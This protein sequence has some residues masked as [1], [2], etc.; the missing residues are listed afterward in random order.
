[1]GQTRI[2]Y[3]LFSSTYN[4]AGFKSLSCRHLLN[5]YVEPKPESDS[6]AVLSMPGS[7]LWTNTGGSQVRAMLAHNDVLYVV[8]DDTFYSVDTAGNKTYRG[9]LT[10]RSGNIVISALNNYIVIADGTDCYSYNVSGATFTNI[11]DGDLPNNVQ[12][13]T[14]ANEYILYIKPDTALVYVSDLS[15]PESINALSFFT[16]GA[17]FD[18]LKSAVSCQNKAYL[19]GDTTTEIWYPSGGQTVPF[20]RETVIQ[21][22]IQAP[23]SCKTIGNSVYW[24]G[25]NKD[26]CV[27]LVIAS[28]GDAQVVTNR[29]FITKVNDYSVTAVTT[30]FGWVD[31]HN[32]HIFYNLTFPSVGVLDGHT[33]SYDI[34][35]GTWLERTSWNPSRSLGAGYDR[36]FASCSEYFNGKQLVGDFQSGKIYQ[37]SPSFYSD[38][39]SEYNIERETTS[40]HI[41]FKDQ[42]FSTSNLQVNFEGGLG[43]DT[44]DDPQVMIYVS[45][46]SGHTWSDPV[47]RSVGQAGE[48]LRRTRVSALG[49]G[50]N[51]TIRLR[52]TDPVPWKLLGAT[53]DVTMKSEAQ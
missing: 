36:H 40:Q 13:L 1:M 18:N 5:V 24:L 46:D 19:F 10:T 9:T 33:W 42:Y 25:K 23:F 35:T 27:G 3:P 26:G 2:T 34:A 39:E 15:N 22:G 14:A 11:S 52:M 6:I 12:H 48:Y 41:N 47:T 4:P 38:T 30:C 17:S 49:G 43:D 32:G 7:E 51:L 37:L 50:Y 53:V 21:L 31:Q 16:C 28:G 44:T 29:D 8:T 45:K 20:D